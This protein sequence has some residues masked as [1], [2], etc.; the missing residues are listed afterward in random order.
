METFFET[1]ENGWLRTSGDSKKKRSNQYD[2]GARF[3]DAVIGR[4]NV[5]DPLSEKGHSWSTYNYALNNPVLF[6]DPDGMWPIYSRNG[7]YLGDDGRTEKGKDL[8]F[9][10][11]RDGKGFKNLVQFTDHH[12]Q[13]QKMANV[14]KQ[15]GGGK[16]EDLWIAHTAYNNATASGTTMYKKLMSGFSSV[17]DKSPLSINSRGYQANIARSAV[18]DVLLGGADP[19]DGAV[20][21]DGTDFLAWG[22]KSP[23]GTP[24]NKFEEYNSISISSSI[25]DTYLTSNTQ[26]YKRGIYKYGKTRNTIPADVFTDPSNLTNCNFYYNTGVKTAFGL[27]ATG[28]VGRSIY[29]KRVKQ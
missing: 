22:L 10:G 21:W 2:Y 3:Y 18:I 24:H 25:Y 15:E 29:W 8:A 17:E 19:T 28:S 9:V 14:V 27:Q 12:T 1:G 20:L 23:N 5:V 4:W 6:I 13:F 16:E 26:Y 7:Q 11:E